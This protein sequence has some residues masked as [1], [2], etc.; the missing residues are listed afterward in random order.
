VITTPFELRKGEFIPIVRL[1]IRGRGPFRFVI[2]TGAS[3]NVIE[4]RLAKKLGLAVSSRSAV[5]I[6]AGGQQQ[7]HTTVLEDVEIGAVK[8]LRLEAFA[9][10]LQGVSIRHRSTIQ[11]VLGYT[12]LKDYRVTLDYPSG[13]LTLDPTAC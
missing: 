11:G 8:G 10:N 3:A 9:M 6:G 4:A 2:D 13:T 1:R 5:A 12:L 7:V